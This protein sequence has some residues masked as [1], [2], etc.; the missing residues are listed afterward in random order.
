LLTLSWDAL[1][2]ALDTARRPAWLRYVA[3]TTLA[4]YAHF[5]T[6]FVVLAQ[7]LVVLIRWRYAEWRALA[8]SGLGMFVLS[9]PFVPFFIVNDDGSQILHV[10]PSDLSD[11]S[12]LFTMFAGSTDPLLIASAA[13]A[14]FGVVATAWPPVRARDRVS[15]GRAL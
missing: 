11:L 7:C 10:R 1:I 8:L 2:E 6:V 4:F 12:D 9:L 5:F 14:A 15:V 3:W 13:L